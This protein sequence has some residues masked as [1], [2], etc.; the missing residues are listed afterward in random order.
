MRIALLGFP[1]ILAAC[2]AAPEGAHA[3]QQAQQAASAARVTRVTTGPIKTDLGYDIVLNKNS[4]LRRE[5]IVVHTSLPAALADSV[6]VFTTYAERE[7][8]Y[9]AVLPVTVKEALSAVEIR[10][11]VFNVFGDLVRS[12]SD[13]EIEDVPA[14][15]TRKFQPTWNIFNE[16]EAA[17]HYASIAYI[18]RVRTAA[19]RVLTADP[20]PV[21]AEAR[22]FSAKLTAADLEPKPTPRPGSQS[23]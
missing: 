14:G 7:Y 19:G 23:Q 22:R 10:V 20:A 16:N 2:E 21:L 17:E 6:G 5:G 12:L 1:V 3:Q 4:S 15:E 13:T 9:N 11:L 8:H 18:A